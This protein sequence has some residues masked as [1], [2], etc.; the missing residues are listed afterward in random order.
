MGKGSRN[1]TAELKATEIYTL[2]LS[3]VPFLKLCWFFSQ[4]QYMGTFLLFQSIL[5][6]SK[7][8]AVC[9]VDKNAIL[10]KLS[11]DVFLLWVKQNIFTSREATD[12][13]YSH[14]VAFLT[15][16]ASGY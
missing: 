16:F 8:M 7:M 15:Y 9:L 4:W 3:N 11:H 12:N 6:L 5:E 1:G 13:W 2:L 14:H 10:L